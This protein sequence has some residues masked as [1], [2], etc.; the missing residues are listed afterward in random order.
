M[1]RKRIQKFRLER[2]DRRIERFAHIVAT[3]QLTGWV[4]DGTTYGELEAVSFWDAV[5][6]RSSEMVQEI[7]A[8]QGITGIIDS[9]EALKERGE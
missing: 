7:I 4:P 2:R 8:S 5:A 9:A 1:L 3:V 6:G